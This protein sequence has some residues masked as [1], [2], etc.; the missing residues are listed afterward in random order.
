[1]T[2]RLLITGAAGLLGSA[3]A[4]RLS[5]HWQLTLF[6]IDTSI[7]PD[8]SA[9][10]VVG[11]MGDRAQVAAAVEGADA[12]L[13]LACRHGQTISFEETLDPNYRGLVALMDAAVSNGVKNV[14]FTSS[15]HGW[16]LYPRLAA[17]LSPDAPPRPDGWYGIN[18]IWSEAVLSFYADTHG[19]AATSLRIGNCGPAIRDE[20]Q[21]HMWISFD[22]LA[23]LVQLALARTDIG[24]IGAFATSD[25]PAPFFDNST[26]K[27]LG[28]A[29]KDRPEDNLADPTLTSQKADAGLFGRSIGGSYA[30]ANFKA[31]ID[32]WESGK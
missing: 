21:T 13:H 10:V 8:D 6:D 28:F 23:Q 1:M 11:D 14:V 17:P 9:R 3:L 24:H 30:V 29:P 19:L 26:A 15:N 20:R 4:K 18:K 12:I 2:K 32:K 27:S 5:K 25:G 31:D 7:P 22:D 16:G